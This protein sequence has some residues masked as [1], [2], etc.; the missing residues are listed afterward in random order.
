MGGRYKA[1]LFFVVLL[2]MVWESEVHPPD[3][4]GGLDDSEM[5]QLDVPF[6]DRITGLFHPNRNTIY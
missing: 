1:G 4:L 2:G 3:L 6:E 5:L